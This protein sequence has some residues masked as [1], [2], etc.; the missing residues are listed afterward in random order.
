MRSNHR[1]AGFQLKAVLALL[2]VTVLVSA[3]AFGQQEKILFSFP[4]FNDVSYPRAGLIVGHTI[5]GTGS[6]DGAYDMGGS[7]F[8]LVPQSGGWTDKVLH[9]F[10]GNGKGG[11]APFAGLIMDKSGN[12]YGTTLFGGNLTACPSGPGCGV[13]FELT[14]SS[15]GVWTEKVLHAFKSTD[16]TGPRAG[17]SFDKS[18]NLYGTT[19]GGGTNGCGNVFEVSRSGK[20]W[21]AK[22]LYSF[23]GSDGCA[24]YAGLVH[25]ASN[26]LYGTTSAGGAYANGTVFELSRN[27]QTWKESVL[28]S[29]DDNGT[30]GYGPEAGVILDG[31]GNLYGTTVYG[32]AFASGCGG[33]SCGTVFE[34]SPGSQGW[35][36]TVLHSFDSNGTDG[37]WPYAGL[38]LDSSGNL[39]GTTAYGGSGAGGYGTVFELSPSKGGWTEHI[40]HNFDDNGQDGLLPMAGLVFDKSGNLYSTT[41]SGGVGYGTVFEVIP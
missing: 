38:L 32:G 15:K 10:S 22:T 5:Y 19:S 30:D 18:G 8:A 37:W 1:S 9:N 16:G 23:S 3:T 6:S 17:L 2:A 24:P 26:N 31:S 35:T 13:V 27:G 39:Y 20:N 28:H 4:N 21:K 34:L 41:Y 11:Y 33:S 36:E 7:V 29:F 14:R 25:D 40:L 12:L